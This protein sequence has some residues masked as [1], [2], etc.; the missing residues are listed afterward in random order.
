[1]IAVGPHFDEPQNCL[2]CTQQ[3]ELTSV[4]GMWQ[5]WPKQSVGITHQ[6]K[7]YIRE[8][9]PPASGLDNTVRISYRSIVS[10][11]QVIRLRN[12]L[13]SL[14]ISGVCCCLMETSKTGRYDDQAGR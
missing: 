7:S 13:E 2:A 6:V 14:L 1:M 5:R 12:N 8:L 4:L 9:L 11:T 3:Q 10:I